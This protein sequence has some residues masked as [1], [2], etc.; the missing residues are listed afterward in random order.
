MYP[1]RDTFVKGKPGR[2]LRKGVSL[3]RSVD[4]KREEREF[5]QEGE[6]LREGTTIV[7]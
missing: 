7:F 2:T 1:S 3:L 6:N 4:G 5:R